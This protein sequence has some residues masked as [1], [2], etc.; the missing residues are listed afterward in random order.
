MGMTES[1]KREAEK[2]N[3]AIVRICLYRAMSDAFE[4]SNS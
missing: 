2:I 1:M 4:F 3:P